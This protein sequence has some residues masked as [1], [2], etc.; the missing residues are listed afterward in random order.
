MEN[1]CRNFKVRLNKPKNLQAFQQ[2]LDILVK[3]RMKG[4]NVFLDE[5]E[6]DVDTKE[7]FITEQVKILQEMQEN[8]NILIEHRSVLNVAAQVISG[9]VDNN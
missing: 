4:E 6:N 5:V 3:E 2:A 8:K 7:R 1:E 9:A